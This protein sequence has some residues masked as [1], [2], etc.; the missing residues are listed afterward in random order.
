MDIRCKK[1]VRKCTV[2]PRSL[3]VQRLQVDEF[4]LCKE[5]CGCVCPSASSDVG[6]SEG[7]VLQKEGHRL[8]SAIRQPL[9]RTRGIS[10]GGHPFLPRGLSLVTVNAGER[11]EATKGLLRREDHCRLK[12]WSESK[13]G[14][15]VKFSALEWCDVT[16]RCCRQFCE[17]R[18]VECDVK[19]CRRLTHI[20]FAGCEWTRLTSPDGVGEDWWTLFHS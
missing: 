8:Q 7:M 11:I 13:T 15:D 5:A 14:T 6:D 10:E 20:T 18:V 3:R 19:H 17:P 4:A 2:W 1:G 16:S 9:M 12:P